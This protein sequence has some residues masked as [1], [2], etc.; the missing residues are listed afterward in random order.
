MCQ[1]PAKTHVRFATVDDAESIAAVLRQAFVEYQALYTPQA[2]AATT[3]PA[4][5]LRERWSEGPV[6][7]ALE[8]DR[9]VGTV[10]AIIKGKTLYVR[11]MAILPAARGHGLGKL[12]LR[13]VEK[14]ANAH[15]LRR[16]V[17]S[18]TPFLLA[19]IRLYER[20]GFQRTA[21]GPHELYGTPLI[22]MERDCPQR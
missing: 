2:F 22:T 11:S 10:A 6:W 1:H 16:L 18:T 20:H 19:A 12:L 4:E 7:V 21:D 14:F 3:P 15:G 13:E 8:N 17:L 9:L 5:T